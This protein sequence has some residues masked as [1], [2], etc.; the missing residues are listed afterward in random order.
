MTHDKNSGLA[1]GGNMPHESILGKLKRHFCM[2]P[3]IMLTIIVM[4]IAAD[5]VRRLLPLPLGL[6]PPTQTISIAILAAVFVIV[7]A[8]FTILL[9]K[10]SVGIKLIIT[11]PYRMVRHPV[12]SIFILIIPAITLIYFNE[13][14]FIASWVAILTISHFYVKREETLL[15]KTFGQEYLDYMKK[16]PAIIPIK[17][18]VKL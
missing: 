6:N 8:W 14:W 13:G 10:H 3:M 16:V 2:G 15:I 7:Y 1:K 18:I 17:G 4:E 5:A 9:R 11:G 12:Y